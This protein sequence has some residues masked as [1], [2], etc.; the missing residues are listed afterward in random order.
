MGLEKL[1]ET[2]KQIDE[3]NAKMAI[4]KVVLEE[5]TISCDELMKE[6]EQSTAAATVKKTEAQAK[7]IEVAAQQK[8]ITKE[9]VCQS[10]LLL[11]I[12]F[13][14]GVLY[15]LTNAFPGR[16]RRCTG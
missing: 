4:Q 13:K 5:K 7:S 8:V 14:H 1:K 9:K 15:A 10:L 6:I 11:L 3:L 12:L 16:S 2:A